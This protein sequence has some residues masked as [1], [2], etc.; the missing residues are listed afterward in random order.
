[1]R[2]R[3]LSSRSTDLSMQEVTVGLALLCFIAAFAATGW[4][5]ARSLKPSLDEA[6]A[7]LKVPPDWF[8][9]VKVEYDTDKPWQE[10][11]LEVR[12]LLS[13]H[14]NREAI[15]LTVFYVRKGDVGDGHEFPM[16]L[17]MGGEHAWA[18]QEYRKRLADYPVGVAHQYR[19]LAT[20]Y[21]HFGEYKAAIELLNVA[22]Q[23]LPEPPWRIAQEA[24][25]HDGLG[26]IYAEMGNLD[27][28]K[29]HYQKARALY[30][31]SDQPYGQHLLHR[32]AAKVKAKLDL[33]TMK[34]IEFSRLRDGTYTG[35]SLGYVDDVTVT[36]AI[37]GGKITDIRVQHQEKID[38]GATTIIPQRI[39][40]QQSLKVDGITGATVTCDAIIDGTLQALRK[41]GLQ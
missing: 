7:S 32:S 27:Q 17:Y 10:A 20:C 3:P 16:Y 4:A 38:Q 31:T 15:K 5:A 34:A 1:M 13:E 19:I 2:K 26:D 11:R 29:L 30:P 37:R 41:A 14:K 6:L 28:A 21:R 12:R 23:R 24:D 25:I 33:L 9:Q 40:A 39:V 35:Q 8:D 18:V 22:L 36:V